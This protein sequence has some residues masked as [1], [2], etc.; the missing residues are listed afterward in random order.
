[1]LRNISV[2]ATR[3]LASIAVTFLVFEVFLRALGETHPAWLWVATVL[4]LLA[5]AY[6]WDQWRRNLLSRSYFVLFAAAIPMCA[7]LG[8]IYVYAHLR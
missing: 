2:N 4:G 6:L 3:V 8:A 1:V 7:T 5:G